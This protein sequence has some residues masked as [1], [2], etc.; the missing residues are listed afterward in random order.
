[1]SSNLRGVTTLF[2]GYY[3]ILYRRLVQTGI[4]YLRHGEPNYFSTS[5]KLLDIADRTAH[6]SNY[7]AMWD[8]DTNLVLITMGAVCA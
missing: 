1:M 4:G 8:H 6:S 2:F 3:W 5:T 7:P